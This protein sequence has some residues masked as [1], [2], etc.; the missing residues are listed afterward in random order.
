VDVTRIISE[1]LG[2]DVP[3]KCSAQS[4]QSAPIPNHTVV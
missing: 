2:T 3:V 4:A 1:Q